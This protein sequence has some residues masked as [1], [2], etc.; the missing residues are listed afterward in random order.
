MTDFNQ[1]VHTRNRDRVTTI[2]IQLN[3]N[4]LKKVL[5]TKWPCNFLFYQFML[6]KSKVDI[7]Y[8]ILLEDMMQIN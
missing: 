1:Q 6:K 8:F 2:R 4:Y 7:P 5:I 3:V